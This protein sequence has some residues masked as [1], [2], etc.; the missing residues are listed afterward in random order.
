MSSL[1]IIKTCSRLK[2]AVLGLGLAVLITAKSLSAA[3]EEAGSAG[4]KFFVTVPPSQFQEG[5]TP[6]QI[7]KSQGAKE[8]RPAAQDPEGH[9]GEVCEGFQLSV[10]FEKESFHLGEPIVAT[11]LIRNA[12]VK[13]VFYRDFVSMRE[14]SAL[15]QFDVLDAQQ[16]PVPRLDPRAPDDVQDGPH[17]PR[18]L[19]PGT[20]CRYEVNLAARFKLGQPG[21]YSVRARRW[22]HKLEGDGYSQLKSSPAVITILNVTNNPDGATAATHAEA[23]SIH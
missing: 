18:L 22:V 6:E 13:K 20:Q 3:G 16:Q 21:K 7:K 17:I 23:P 2:L 8:S 11:V 14:D 19:H 5:P 10:R 9:W 15:C 4:T 12:T 1:S